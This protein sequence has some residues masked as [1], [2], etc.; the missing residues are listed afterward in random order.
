MNERVKEAK[1]Y[2]KTQYCK[3]VAGNQSYNQ[4]RSKEHICRAD[5]HLDEHI[6]IRT[7]GRRNSNEV[8]QGTGLILKAKKFY[9]II[10]EDVKSAVFRDRKLPGLNIS[11][12][13]WT[14]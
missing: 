6:F 13:A 7:T 11:L 3:Q 8:C 12:Q 1:Q 4:T 5:R 2:C 9:K 10:A 14:N